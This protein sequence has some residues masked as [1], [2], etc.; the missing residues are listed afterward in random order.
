[1]ISHIAGFL[2]S[3]F[4]VAN[5]SITDCMKIENRIFQFSELSLKPDPPV[6]GNP[7]EMAVKFTN[8]GGEL[9]SGTSSTKLSLNFIPYPVQ[10]QPLCETTVCPIITGYNDRSTTSTW[11]S[12]ISG[13]IDS[14]LEWFTEDGTQVL[15]IHIATKVS[16]SLLRGEN[17]TV[18]LQPLFEF[19]NLNDPVAKEELDPSFFFVYEDENKTNALVPEPF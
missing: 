11:P 3:F 18:D 6:P 15:C 14:K 13:M 16:G 7:V 5:A 12:G 2:L 17:T 8:T 1:M 19:L 10:I 9:D 4:T